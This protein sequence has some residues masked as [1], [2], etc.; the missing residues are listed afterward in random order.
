MSLL[1]FIFA[2]LLDKI[3][4]FLLMNDEEILIGQAGLVN[5]SFNSSTMFLTSHGILSL[6]SKKVNVLK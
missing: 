4:Y 1:L 2:I 6:P 5:C 3:L